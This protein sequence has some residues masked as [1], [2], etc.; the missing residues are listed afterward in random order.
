MKITSVKKI[1]DHRFLNLFSASYTDQSRKSKEW[2]FASRHEGEN[3]L[4][5]HYRHPDAV[6]IVPFHMAAGKLII[7]REFRV[8]LGGYQYGFP[9]GLLDPGETI[10]QAGRRELFEET[11]LTVNR[12]LKK[13]PAV[14][15]S[16]GLTDESI[17]MLYVECNGTPTD[18]RHSDS[19]DIEVVMVSRQQASD[20]TADH[21]LKLDVKTWI[22]LDRFAS[23][24]SV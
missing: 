19:E 16:S 3:P 21:D 11:G 18:K 12:V 8:A 24:G 1:T 6:V 9:A 20:L 5:K 2:I 4:L 17:S 14:F 7:V 13:S 22:V 10:E 23:Q 15:S